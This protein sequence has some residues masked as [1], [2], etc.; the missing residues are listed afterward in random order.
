MIHATWG[1]WFVRE[2]IEATAVDGL[3][4]WYLGCMGLIVRSSTTTL[5]FDPYFA[6]GDPPLLTRM[7]PVPLDPADATACDAVL[8]SHE[9]LDHMHPPS[10]AP[11]IEDLG[12]DRYAPSAA[13]EEPD[14]GGPI[15]ESAS[16]DRAVEPG[17]ELS[18][19]DLTVHVRGANDPDAIEPVSYV[20]EHEAGTLFHG[21]DSRPA[22]AFEAI[23]REF[24]IDLGVLALGTVGT[25]AQEDGPART[26]WYSDENQVIDAAC[27]LQLDRL[28]PG[29][30]DMWKGVSADPK[31]LHEHGATRPYP[32]VIERAQIGDRLDVGEP[33]IVQ[34]RHLS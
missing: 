21:G 19:G 3:S 25:M 23:G 2:E 7:I 5:Y 27:Q 29:H 13:Y 4:V 10:H 24:D 33:G 28:L 15:L 9:H 20:V 26:R 11:L 32:R 16:E 31:V 14:Y 18:I 34:P 6:D 8:V 1:D 30:Y 17:D 12:A 22:E